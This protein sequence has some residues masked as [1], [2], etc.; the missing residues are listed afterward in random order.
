VSIA[1]LNLP[2]RDL[3][4]IFSIGT[5]GKRGICRCCL[6]YCN[7]VEMHHVDWS[8]VCSSIGLWTLG[9]CACLQS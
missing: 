1:Q 5:C 3:L 2:S 4:K 8:C 9:C 6:R 7:P